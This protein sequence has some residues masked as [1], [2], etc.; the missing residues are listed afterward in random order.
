MFKFVT[1]SCILIL[2]VLASCLSNT[3]SE[4]TK[5]LSVAVKEKKISAKTREKIILE[6]DKL[7]DQDKEKARQYVLQIVSAVEMGGDSTHIEVARKQVLEG[8]KD[9]ETREGV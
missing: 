9:G 3:Q 8:M 4:L 7:R 6:Y 5:S 2:L 1:H